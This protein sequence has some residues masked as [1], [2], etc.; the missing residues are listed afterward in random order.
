M[1]PLQGQTGL[2]LDEVETSMPTQREPSF[3]DLRSDKGVFL[4]VQ[5]LMQRLGRMK[6]DKTMKRS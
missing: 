6:E 3:A 4:S 2:R 5:Y 1:I